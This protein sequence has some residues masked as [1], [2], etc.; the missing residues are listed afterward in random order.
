MDRRVVRSDRWWRNRRV[1]L[2]ALVVGIVLAAL[3]LYHVLPSPNSL[4]VSS[5]AVRSATVAREPFRDYVPLRGEVAARDTTFVS[6]IVG[7]QVDHVIANDGALVARGQ[8]LAALSNRSLELDVASRSADIAGQLGNISAQRL[9]IQRNRIDSESEIAAAKNALQKAQND[10]TKKRFLL[11]KGI[12]NKAAVQPLA[13]DVAF[14]QSRVDALTAARA[15]ESGTLSDQSNQ[16][17]ATAQQL[18]R[19]LT[20]VQD[21]LDA[22]TLR[23]P[24]AGRLTGF[25]LQPGQT[26]NAGD[27][28]AQIDAQG[29]WKIT[30]DVDQYYLGRVSAGQH[31]MADIDG[32]SA[33]LRVARVLPQVTDGRFRVELYFEGAAPTGLNRGQTLDVRLILG[34]DRPAV[35]APTGAW[36][37]AGG[38]IAFVL[39]DDNRA[40][41]RSV[42]TGRRNPEQVEITSGLQPGD[43][44]VTSSIDSYQPYQHLLIR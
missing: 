15:Q 12:V 20:M 5:E 25:D 36:L 4:T 19:S 21:S 39:T 41:R 29:S 11:E 33:M 2:G 30:A 3:L 42:A 43:R 13:D 38:N 27:R 24:M 23:A 14:Q 31:A 44:I 40:E 26:L 7:G 10:L 32:R 1:Q 17:G 22:L 35:V 18:R 16:V 34:A 9:S 6:A 8:P 37:D 28:I